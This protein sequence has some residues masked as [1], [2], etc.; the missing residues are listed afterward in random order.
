MTNIG[1]AFDPKTGFFTASVS[2]PYQ[3]HATF[4]AAPHNPGDVHG[5]IV[6]DG[7][8]VAL[9]I[10]D[11]RHGFCDNTGI[12]AVVH[13]PAGKKVYVQN[14]DPWTAA[15]YEESYFSFS[16]FLLRAY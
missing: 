3:F 5:A 14:V 13:V 15:Y 7:R 12:D 4:M 10:S 9:S 8:S 2:G 16:G 11:S 6:V 1:N